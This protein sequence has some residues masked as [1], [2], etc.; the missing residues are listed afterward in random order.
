MVL[1]EKYVGVNICTNFE[2]SECMD[3]R[4]NG[5]CPAQFFLSRAILPEKQHTE[6]KTDSR[7]TDMCHEIDV[8]LCTP[9]I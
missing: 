6:D 3:T 7:T 5:S 1:V 4:L 9:Q 2:Q 8:G